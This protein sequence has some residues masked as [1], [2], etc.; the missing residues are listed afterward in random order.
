MIVGIHQREAVPPRSAAS[1]LLFNSFSVSFLISLTFWHLHSLFILVT[2]RLSLR[3]G[4]SQFPVRWIGLYVDGPDKKKN[5]RQTFES[6]VNIHTQ[7][8]FSLLLGRRVKHVGWNVWDLFTT[9]NGRENKSVG[10]IVL[11]WPE[12]S[13]GV[14][15]HRLVFTRFSYSYV[16]SCWNIRLYSHPCSP[17]LSLASLC[18]F[19]RYILIINIGVDPIIV[20]SDP[21]CPCWQYIWLRNWCDQSAT[22]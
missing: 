12:L 3:T 15:L 16:I 21:L 2:E 19:F 17:A 18:F 20:N 9:K 8:W 4:P 1:P 10:F 5:P 13:F 7:L 14:R 6:C 22:L 11:F